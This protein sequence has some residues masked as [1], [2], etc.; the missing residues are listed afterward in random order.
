MVGYLEYDNLNYRI[1]LLS[2]TKAMNDSVILGYSWSIENAELENENR[3]NEALRLSKDV[4]EVR[5]IIHIRK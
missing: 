4:E 1:S 3:S 5:L 2:T